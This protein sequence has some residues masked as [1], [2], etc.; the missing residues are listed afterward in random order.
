[1]SLETGASLRAFFHGPLATPHVLFVGWLPLGLPLT[2]ANTVLHRLAWTYAVRICYSGS[3]PK[4]RLKFRVV[5]S[6]LTLLWHGKDNCSRNSWRYQKT[7][8]AET[9]NILKKDKRRK[10]YWN[11]NIET[12]L[13]FNMKRRRPLKYK[14]YYEFKQNQESFNTV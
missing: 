13:W 4:A 14:L 7:W 5:R 6:H 2:W 8:Q 11:M 1:M 3:F 10:R 12:T 9:R